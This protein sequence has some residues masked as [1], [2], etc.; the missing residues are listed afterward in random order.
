MGYAKNLA[1][2]LTAKQQLT[3]DIFSLSVPVIS[4]FGTQSCK[5]ISR[6]E[7]THHRPVT[8]SFCTNLGLF[9]YDKLITELHKESGDGISTSVLILNQI[10]KKGIQALQEGIKPQILQKELQEGASLITARLLKNSWPIDSMDK[11]KCISHTA[12]FQDNEITEIVCNLLGQ[13]KNNDPILIEKS[14]ETTSFIEVSSGICLQQ[15]SAHSLFGS[16]RMTLRTYIEN[17]YTFISNI[18]ITSIQDIF[19]LIAEL[20]EKKLL[21]ICEN[22]SSQILSMLITNKIKGL[23]DVAVIKTLKNPKLDEDTLQNI[24]LLTGGRV[25]SKKNGDSLKNCSLQDLGRCARVEISPQTTI[26]INNQIPLISTSKL[27]LLPENNDNKKFNL[28]GT[29]FVGA[30]KQTELF[31][32]KCKILSTVKSTQTALKE[33]SILG[34]GVGLYH[35]ANKILVDTP[36]INLGTSIL[37]H[38]CFSPLKKIVNNNVRKIDYKNLLKEILTC[39]NQQVGFNKNTFTL[40]N[41]LKAGIFDSTQIIIN[42]I[43]KAT[44]IACE[45]FSCDVVI[46]EYKNTL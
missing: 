11:L 46:E 13:I 17:A 18:N 35:T 32:K 23:I 42:S 5:N 31:N 26:I 27:T 22:M 6:N 36:T 39:K 8:T 2:G 24:T 14:N 38:A 33:G 3:K 25:F 20:P 21:I 15:G 40:D 1:F 12:S 34:G 44:Q 29:I 16:D 45:I 37:C 7:I 19:T 4:S 30:S 28:I 41:L 43:L 9:F 10:L